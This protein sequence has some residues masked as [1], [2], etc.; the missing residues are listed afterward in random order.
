MTFKD[1]FP[2]GWIGID[3]DGSLVTY[4]G[5]RGPDV[6]GD[7]IQSM[8]DRVK[9]WIAEGKNVRIMTARVSPQGEMDDK[10][11]DVNI[12]R[13]GIE[14]WC[15]EKFGKVLPV[16]H[17][18]DYNMIELWDDRAVQLEFNTG[19]VIQEK[20]ESETAALGEALE[21]LFKE[22]VDLLNKGIP[23]E[24]KIIAHDQKTLMDFVSCA[25]SGAFQ[26]LVDGIKREIELVNRRIQ[27]KDSESYKESVE[28]VFGRPMIDSEAP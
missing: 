11:N 7:P 15:L 12:A 3:F 26:P 5:W 22:W 10:D 21:I 23:E 25:G 16:T 13:R 27:Y 8:V 6:F 4:D 20:L 24:R 19:V 18:K 9:Q 14:A 1:E 28:K 2:D 17:E